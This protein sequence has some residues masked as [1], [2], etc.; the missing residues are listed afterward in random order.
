VL[1][2]PLRAI[3]GSCQQAH[4]GITNS[5]GVWCLQMGWIARW[6]SPWMLFNLVSA[7]FFVPAFVH[8]PLQ[9]MTVFLQKWKLLQKFAEISELSKS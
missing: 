8:N 6:S 1:A 7:P 9:K 2:E 4:L 5:E 3:P